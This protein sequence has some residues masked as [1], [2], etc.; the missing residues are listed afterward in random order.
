M[1]TLYDDLSLIFASI[2]GGLCIG[3]IQAQAGGSNGGYRH[4]EKGHRASHSYQEYARVVHVEPMYRSVRVEAPRE[5]CW[6]E[7]VPERGRDYHNGGQRRGKHASSYT[8]HILGAVVGAAVGRQFGRGRGQ[9]AATVAGAVL[10]GSIGRDVHRR[11]NRDDGYRH[12]GGHG[13]R[14]QVVVATGRR[15]ITIQVT[16]LP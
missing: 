9:D 15:Q 13:S 14:Y 1:R 7:R 2:I 5:Q 4:A 8:P 11:H 16:K 10:G 6:E 3:P 12:G